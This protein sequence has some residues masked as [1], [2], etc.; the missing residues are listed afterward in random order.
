MLAKHNDSKVHSKDIGPT[1]KTS[2]FWRV[3]CGS[4]MG[5]ER[6]S[7]RDLN[8]AIRFDAKMTYRAQR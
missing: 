1:F 4:V 5:F 2:T 6:D 7:F 3:C 8:A